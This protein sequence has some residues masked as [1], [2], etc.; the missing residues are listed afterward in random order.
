MKSHLKALWS[1]AAVAALAG[2]LY[3]CS[4][5]TEGGAVGANR[6][7]LMLVSSEQLEQMAAQQYH[8]LLAQASQKRVLNTDAT[9][10]QRVRGIAGRI[11]PQTQVFRPDARNWQWE[12]NV[13]TSDQVNAFCMPG[14]KIM[15]FRGIIERLQLSDDEAAAV[16][17]HEIAHAL[18]QHGR[19]RMSEAV[20]KNVG[21]NLVALYFGL[22]DLGA[23]ALAQAAQLAISL[24][25]SRSHE[26]DADLAG[27]EL[28]AR[29][30]FDP[31]AAVTLWRKMAAAN[32]TQPPQFL[33]TH[34]GHENRI[35]EIEASLPKVLPLYE[36]AVTATNKAPRRSRDFGRAQLIWMAGSR[37][38]RLGDQSR[39]V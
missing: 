5:T 22:G 11:I 24:P 9:A 17:G 16:I 12:V 39:P 18:L 23:T 7:Q 31:R 32:A 34:P 26:I 29:A 20:L 21:V 27:I 35:R 36:K 30:G 8:Q 1:L 4:T 28:A 13:I 3:G 6:Q 19:A 2:L 10:T 38:R 33:S 25:Y 15:V 37:G 14:G